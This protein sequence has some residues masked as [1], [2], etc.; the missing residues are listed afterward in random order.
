MSLKNFA[1][2]DN[3]DSHKVFTSPQMANTSVSF[4]IKEYWNKEYY[5]MITGESLAHEKVLHGSKDSKRRMRKLK[6]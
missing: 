6:K 4:P 2:I 1:G 5:D 3:Y